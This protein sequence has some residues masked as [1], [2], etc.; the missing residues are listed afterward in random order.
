MRKVKK[1]ILTQK[2]YCVVVDPVDDQFKPQLGKRQ[3]RRGCRSFFLH[4]GRYLRF[5]LRQVLSYLRFVS[6]CPVSNAV[7]VSHQQFALLNHSA[8]LTKLHRNVPLVN[9]YKNC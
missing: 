8:N 1:I 4:P 3:L 9:R 5:K 7:G 2:Q 6:R